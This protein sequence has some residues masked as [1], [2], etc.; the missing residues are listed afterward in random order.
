MTTWH[1]AASRVPQLHWPSGA[2][3]SPVS[4]SH[5]AGPGFPQADYTV[6]PHT[7]TT[8]SPMCTTHGDHMVT[9]AYHTR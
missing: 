1:Y 5:Q 3:Q 2:S 8:Q 9:N 7:E 4:A 6:I